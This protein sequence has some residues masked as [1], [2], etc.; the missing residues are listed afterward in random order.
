M[1]KTI[2]AN[3]SI[4]S[5]FDMALHDIAAQHAGVPLYKFLGGEKSKVLATDMTVSIGDAE[6]MKNDAIRFK[7]E[8]F[9]AIKVKLGGTKE[10]DVARIKAIREGISNN[11]PLRID[12]NQGWKTADYAIEVLQALGQY[13]IEH[14][15]EPISR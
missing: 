7:A 8:G 11:H 6:K 10:D 12:A 13:N 2:Y 3:H 4:K 14:C 9:P 15:E 5:A 1:D